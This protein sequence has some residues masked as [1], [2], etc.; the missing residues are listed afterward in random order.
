METIGARIALYRNARRWTQE[1]L[2]DEIGMPQSRLSKIENDKIS[3]RWEIINKIAEKLTVP[4]ISLLPV[5]ANHIL[6][7]NPNDQSGEIVPHIH[8]DQEAD[9][10]LL[11]EELLKAKDESLEAKDRLIRLLEQ[12]KAK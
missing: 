6:P 12:Q 5:A 10:H 3:P 11:W 9:L 4:V 1:H 7:D 8:T 2:A